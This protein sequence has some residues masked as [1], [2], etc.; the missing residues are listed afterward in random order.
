MTET[1]SVYTAMRHILENYDGLSSTDD[2]NY[3][4]MATTRNTW[5][6]GRQITERKAS[7]D[8][9]D[10]LAK[11]SFVSIYPTRKGKRGV[12]A[13]R[14]DTT[15]IATHDES[16]ILSTADHRP[17]I[18]KYDKIPLSKV[19]NDIELNYDYNPGLKKYNKSILITK[20]D[21]STFPAFYVSTGTDSSK[22]WVHATGTEGST[23]K[24]IFQIQ[25]SA[26]PELY[27]S[28]G[29]Y[30]TLIGDSGFIIAFGQI[31]SFKDDGGGAYYAFGLFDNVFGLT[32]YQETTF[33]ID[34][35]TLY[36]QTS[37]I[38]MWT[39][40]A[41]GVPDYSQAKIW[42]EI[43]HNS[44]L[45]TRVVNRLKYDCD[46]F[47][48]NADFDEPGGTND[49]AFYLLAEIL[50]YCT[51]QKYLVEYALPINATNLALELN[52]PIY[53]NDQK[54]T[55][56]TD[57]LGYISSIKIIPST[58]RPMMMIQ[59]I[60]EPFNI[61][62]YNLIIETGS[63]PDTITESGSQTDTITEGAQ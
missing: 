27:A 54:F 29:D 46:W 50:R 31:T 1:N 58:K 9:L 41:S 57:R 10:E 30:Y 63:A 37:G 39:T 61:E 22:S 17:M 43:C 62:D 5:R 8:Y 14:E 15:I 56:N 18:T 21:Q 49:T 16:E 44:Y 33:S 19:Y 13:W 35:G 3:N 45:E 38:P 23:G 48:N 36:H 32:D 40:Y 53:F 2:I 60:L 12:K 52:D 34:G 24:W 20:T 51:L 26:D 4:D 11:Q 55:N 42:W 25:F 47:I 59:L 6:V 7:S 28:I